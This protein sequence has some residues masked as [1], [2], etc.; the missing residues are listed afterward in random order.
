MDQQVQ[1]VERETTPTVAPESA[2]A[3]AQPWLKRRIVF[4][5]TV[6]VPTLIAS[7]YFGLFASGVYTTESRFVLR[8]PQKS[9]AQTGGLLTNFLQSTGIATSQDD[10]YLV[11]DFILSRDALRELDEKLG[12]RAAYSSHNIDWFDRF[13]R[14][15]W[16]RSFEAF[17]EYYGDHVVEVD[18]DPASS[19]ATLTVN[20][21]TAQNALRIN[22]MLL[23]ISE[24]LVNSLNDR[25]RHDL[26]QFAEQDVNIAEQKAQDASL[27]L[28]AY[29][30]KQAVY[31]PDQQ[32]EIQLQSVATIQADLVSTEAQLAQLRKISPDNPQIP[33]LESRAETLRKAI[34]TEAGKVTDSH[35]SLSARS[36][37][38]ERLALQSDFADKQVAVA[39]AELEEARS[40]ARRQQLYLER[41]VQPSL[42]DKA[43]TPRR[44]RSVFTVFLVGL[45]L[46]GVASLVLAAIREHAD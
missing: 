10:T 40:E 6:L 18:Y 20:A 11:H 24:S 46:C 23:E 45:I 22:Q 3:P 29:R 34:R 14:M 13:P 5:L 17:Y 7:L 38:F 30:S 16:D 32:A 35:G 19:I 25:S 37:E 2:T 28:L 44:V 27:A 9:P 41:L 8:S 15:G 1:P 4:V 39:L 36:P 33:G 31:A 43:M 12:I 26:V 21:F 42:P